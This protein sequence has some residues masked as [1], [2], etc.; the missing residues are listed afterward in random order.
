MADLETKFDEHV[1]DDKERHKEVMERT[2]DI[3]RKLEAAVITRSTDHDLLVRIDEGLKDTKSKIENL[4]GSVEQAHYKFVTKEQFDPVQKLVYG[5][6]VTILLAFLGAIVG[7][8]I[9]R[10]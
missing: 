5:C 7:L 8:V 3:G 4:Q 9:V 1:V 10:T 2:N 6:V